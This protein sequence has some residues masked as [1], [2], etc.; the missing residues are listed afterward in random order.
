MKRTVAVVAAAVM[1]W[2]RTGAVGGTGQ[3]IWFANQI[4]A[5]D[6]GGNPALWNNP[7]ATTGGAMRIQTGSQPALLTQDVALQL[8]VDAPDGHGGY[9]WTTLVTLLLSAPSG[10]VPAAGN[11]WVGDA[12]GDCTFWGEP[13]AFSDPAG[14]TYQIPNTNFSS[15]PDGSYSMRLYAW[16]G[17]ESSYAAATAD[18][19]YVADSGVFTEVVSYGGI[20]PSAG[21]L[22]DLPG[23]VLAKHLL[24]GDANGDGQVNINDLTIVL[25][26]FGQTGRT[27]SQG[28]FTGDG[29]VDINDLTIVLAHFGQ[30]VGAA[31]AA[32]MTA[33]PEPAALA[34]AATGIAAL[35]ACAGRRRRTI[36]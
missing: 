16:I 11:N 31:S 17:A 14:Q 13:G 24:P 25:S 35:L 3:E 27:W 10:Q 7:Q 29:T 33:V 8:D 18:N 19:E 22:I 9:A 32:G 30:S 6:N 23:M 36:I 26:N 1:L 2:L 4:N 34:L 21:E 5:P 15:G 28:E 12:T 20:M